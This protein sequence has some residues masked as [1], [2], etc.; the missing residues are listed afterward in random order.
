MWFK[1]KPKMLFRECRSLKQQ[2]SSTCYFEDSF[3]SKSLVFSVQT[4]LM[5]TFNISCTYSNAAIRGSHIGIEPDPKSFL[6][7]LVLLAHLWYLGLGQNKIYSI[8]WL[9]RMSVEYYFEY[10]NI[11]KNV[12][13]WLWTWDF[14]YFKKAVMSVII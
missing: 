9:G 11:N 8:R 4:V 1:I 6:A 10:E 12:K 3:T 14:M 5:L 13:T 2:I 7:K